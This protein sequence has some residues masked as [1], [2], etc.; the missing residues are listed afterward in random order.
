[1]GIRTKNLLLGA[2]ALVAVAFLFSG[3]SLAFDLV[4][5]ESV[6]GEVVA[7][8]RTDDAYTADVTY[9]ASEGAYRA[10][11]PFD[12]DSIP[13]DG[14]VVAVW[15]NPADPTEVF[16]GSDGRRR[17]ALQ[18]I[19]GALL[20]LLI[21]GLL[22]VVWRTQPR[23]EQEQLEGA[24]GTPVTTPR[25]RARHRSG[26]GFS[27][28][29]AKEPDSP[30]PVGE[31]FTAEFTHV[32][33]SAPDDHGN[34]Q[35]RVGAERRIGSTREQYM[36]EW[37]SDDPSVGILTSGGRVV[38]TPMSDGSVQIDLRERKSPYDDLTPS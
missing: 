29:R 37:R 13:A 6:A 28:R 24:E 35:Y 15:Y 16:I 21:L 33:Q 38:V 36:S 31:S 5:F 4:R 26:S 9:A 1:M 3:M 25:Q 8:Q 14:E 20:A 12:A 19:F 34:V 27:S 17:Q 22:F 32:E 7:V 30:T 23:R 11:I 2:L 18:N 10:S